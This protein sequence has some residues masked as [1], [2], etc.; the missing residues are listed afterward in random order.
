MS[1][2][3]GRGAPRRGK[4]N[5]I[6]VTVPNAAR[7][8]DFMVGGRDN[9]AVDREASRA[10]IGSMPGLKRVTDQ[11]RAFRRRVITYL[12]E[13]GIRQFLDVGT[14]IVPPGTTHEDAQ[15]LDPGCRVLYTESD[16][17]MLSR[18]QARMRSAPGGVVR[19]VDG[20]IADV[21]AIIAS[22]PPTLDL[23]R[24]VGLLLLST[25]A[26]VPTTI[27]AT[28]AVSSLL[29]PA[30]SGS[31]IAIYHLA[32][33]LGPDMP[34]AIRNW[35]KTVP[36]PVTLRSHADVLGLVEG[37]DLV[38]PGVV[39]ISRWYPGSAETAETA[40]TVPVHGVVARKR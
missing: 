20:D 30:P 12:V 6:D 36:V 14:G 32:N 21:D 34:A 13:A 22:A 19:C 25:L 40:K 15:G 37:L 2:Q 28:R 39:P 5:L 11:A 3:A 26:H 35:N 1:D 31:Y 7:V 29:A 27:A 9:F 8:A 10:F 16:P 17:M 18:A 4:P 38:E 23:S 33:D 24:P